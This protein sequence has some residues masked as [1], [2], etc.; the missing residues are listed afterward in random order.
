MADKLEAKTFLT[1]IIKWT[2]SAYLLVGAVFVLN[3]YLMRF[4]DHAQTW[5]IYLVIFFALAKTAYFTTITLR[6]VNSSI[7]QCH[8]FD[9]LLWVFG[10]L[11]LLVILSFAA[12]FNCLSAVDKGSLKGLETTLDGGLFENLFS[13][14]YFSIVTFASVG[15]GDIVPVSAP[16]KILVILEICQSFILIVFGLSNIN[17][18]H[19]MTES[20]KE[21]NGE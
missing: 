3:I 10:M 9:K 2:A 7:K 8:S 4:I 17:N 1:R 19:V 15:Y 6:Q 20:H 12:D 14:F 21:M 13:Y 11:I 18:I 5:L 16:A